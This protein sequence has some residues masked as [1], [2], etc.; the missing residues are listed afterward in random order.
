ML[1]KEIFYFYA[2]IL[3]YILI[4]SEYAMDKINS[5]RPEERH[6][7][8]DRGT[9]Y[10]HTGVYNEIKVAGSYLCKRCGLALFR[11]DSQFSSGCGWPSFDAEIPNTIHHLPDKNR[12]EIR[13][14][15]CDSHLGH[16]F[17][18][19]GF[20]AKNRR[21]CVNSTSLEFVEN[22]VVLDTEEAIVA[23]GCFWGIDYYFRQLPG[24]LKLEVGYTGGTLAHPTYQQ[25]CQGNSGHFEAT[26]VIY[27]IARV[28]YQKV[29]QYFFEIHDPTQQN[30]Q[31]PD[32]GHQYQSAVFYY[33][34]EQ[35][36]IAQSLLSQLK[37]KGYKAS[38]QLLPVTTFWAAEEYHQNYYAKQHN[39]PYCHRFVKKF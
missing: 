25:I 15:R 24:V 36:A 16:I 3:K 2:F 11:A 29:L 38:T 20:T 33:N 10:P 22:E 7:I 30:G 21:Y 23:G 4:Q 18:G 1:M 27:D 19:E 35:H 13:C 12:I 6:I 8:C 5:L 14:N 37:E 32:I 9:E 31:G 17:T 28:N 26:R 39:Q 34:P